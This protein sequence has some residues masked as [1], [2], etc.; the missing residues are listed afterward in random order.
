M[1]QHRPGGNAHIASDKVGTRSRVS[2]GTQCL[3]TTRSRRPPGPGRPGPGSDNRGRLGPVRTVTQEQNAR[4]DLL[5]DFGRL[6]GVPVLPNTS[7]NENEPIVMTPEQATET[8]LKTKMDVLVL[9]NH[10]V[11]RAG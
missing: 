3:A 4:Y 7:F 1:I 11:W 8:F 9:G 2:R 10:V 5:D 6:T